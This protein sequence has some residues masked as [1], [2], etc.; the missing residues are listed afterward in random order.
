[1]PNAWRLQSDEAASIVSLWFDR[2]GTSQNS[3]DEASIAELAERLDEIP[4]DVKA[5]A[6]R[7][8]KPKGFCAGADLKWIASRRSVDEMIAFLKLG[9][10]VLEKVSTLPSVAVVHGVCLGGGLELA[11]ACRAE[12][13]STPNRRRV[14]A[15]PKSNTDSSPVGTRSACSLA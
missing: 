10:V 8:S 2:P 15:L 9:R 1:M 11:L 6:V 13:P 12:S 7:S 4:S 3:L 5:V 14:S